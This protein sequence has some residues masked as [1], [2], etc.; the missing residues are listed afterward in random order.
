MDLCGPYNMPFQSNFESNKI[1]FL[2]ITDIFSRYMNISPLIKITSKEVTKIFK[3]KWL[4]KFPKP[5]VFITDK[6]RQFTGSEFNDFL[7]NNNIIHSL[8]STLNPTGNSISERKNV[9]IN[10]IMRICKN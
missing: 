6:G 7:N 2:T 8:S 4:S 9:E 5:K 3:N 1:Y 10:Q